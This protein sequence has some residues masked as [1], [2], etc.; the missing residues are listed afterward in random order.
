L[1]KSGVGSMLQPVEA[2]QDYLSSF[3][4]VLEQGTFLV[5][6]HQESECTLSSPVS[7]VFVGHGPND[8]KESDEAQRRIR[9]QMIHFLRS[10][11]LR[12]GAGPVARS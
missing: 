9:S 10:F 2:V 3:L 4:M 6:I 11:F 12:S 5:I 1:W 7:Q 8:H